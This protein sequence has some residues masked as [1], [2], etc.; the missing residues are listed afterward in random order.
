MYFAENEPP[1]IDANGDGIG[2]YDVF[3]LDSKGVYQ[4]VGKWRSSEDSFEVRV[5]QV[6][7]GFRLPPGVSPCDMCPE[8]EVPDP[9]L[10]FCVPIPP[11]SM[12][13]DSAW[14]LIP[15]G[16]SLLGL[17]STIFVVGVFLKFSNTPVVSS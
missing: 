11:V 7:R 2:R 9:S 3:Q 8:G 10:S 13:W 12:R 5:E 6:R 14:A 17:T 15:A 1:L 16:F 4:K